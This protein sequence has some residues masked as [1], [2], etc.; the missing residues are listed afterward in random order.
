MKKTNLFKQSVYELKS[1]KT[2]VFT[3]MLIAVYI[4]VYMF[5]TIRINEFLQVRFQSSIL[6]II[7]YMFGPVVSGIAGAVADI[8]KL[9][10]IPSGQIIIGLTISEILRGVLYGVCFYKSKIT[11]S[12]VLI[13]VTI[14]VFIINVLMNTFWL[15]TYYGTNFWAILT[16]RFTK[17]LILYP[18]KLCI[19]YVVLKAFSRIKIL[20]I[21]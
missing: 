2:I 5:A 9:F 17:E 16:T 19:Y 3:A 14:S 18:I 6:A 10:I 13:A 11:F 15:S 8:L 21:E 4:I 12:R 7:G 20:N 1:T